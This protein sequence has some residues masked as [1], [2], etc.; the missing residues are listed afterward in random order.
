VS[1]V[2]GDAAHEPVSPDENAAVRRS[3][4]RFLRYVAKQVADGTQ[5]MPIVDFMI[6]VHVANPARDKC[7]VER[8]GIVTDDLHLPEEIMQWIGNKIEPR[9]MKDDKGNV[10][11][12]GGTYA[13][14]PSMLF[15]Q[16]YWQ[17]DEEKP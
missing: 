10:F 4:A 1:A 16:D 17:A 2:G 13:F 9:I 15:K 11:L 7:Y 14:G 5:G 12:E 8:V 6:F 3:I